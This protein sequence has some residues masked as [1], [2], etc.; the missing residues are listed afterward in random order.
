[1]TACAELSPTTT[2]SAGLRSTVVNPAVSS[3]TK[4]VR[5]GGSGGSS[6]GTRRTNATDQR[7]SAP[8]SAKTAAGPLSA[9]R[10]PPSAGPA[11]IPTLEIVLPTR[12]AAV[13]SSGEST[14]DGSR[15]ACAGL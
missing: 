1:M 14:S 15:A 4:C 8:V 5:S 6:R 3:C 2:R 9:S 7:V 13:S 11:N 12:L 10:T